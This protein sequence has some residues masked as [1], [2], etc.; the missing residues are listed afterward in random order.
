MILNH[1]PS[2]TSW[3]SQEKSP[4]SLANTGPGYETMP[5]LALR[6]AHVFLA[7]RSQERAL[8][9]IKTATAEIQSRYSKD[10][11]SGSL[12]PSAPP[13]PP[14]LQQHPLMPTP[15]L[16]FLK[17]DLKDVNKAHQAAQVFLKKDLPL[18]ILVNNSGRMFATFQLNSDGIE[19]MFAINY[20]G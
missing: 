14:Q 17:L 6:G 7:C 16:E 12:S 3:T 15:K 5:A 1:S 2:T 9:A 18:H 8:N 11:A 4:S 10:A 20:I 13:P 19:A